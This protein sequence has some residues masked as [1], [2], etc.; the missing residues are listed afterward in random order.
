VLVVTIA[1]CRGEDRRDSSTER[2]H[3]EECAQALYGLVLEVRNGLGT[4]MDRHDG[5]CHPGALPQSK[6]TDAVWRE[7]ERACGPVAAGNDAALLERYRNTRNAA[8]QVEREQAT[9]RSVCI[10]PGF[11]VPNLAAWD[12]ANAQFDAG[13]AALCTA[14]SPASESWC[15]GMLQILAPRAPR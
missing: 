12:A 2:N 14:T 3:G 1:A 7:V 5:S 8:E 10:G 13:L 9:I 11:P 6:P 15:A 4:A